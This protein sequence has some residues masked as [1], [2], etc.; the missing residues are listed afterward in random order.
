M[1][2][3]VIM[4]FYVKIDRVTISGVKESDLVRVIRSGLDVKPREYFVCWLE[5]K[6]V[7]E[8]YPETITET[9]KSILRSQD[10]VI[11]HRNERIVTVKLDHG[12]DGD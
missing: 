7:T 1:A 11:V 6:P 3:M 9:V 4:F 8:C 12:T 2:L 5:S 10:T